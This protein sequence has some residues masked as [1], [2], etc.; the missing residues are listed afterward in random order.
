MLYR[1]QN[2]TPSPSYRA[3]AQIHLSNLSGV[4][5]HRAILMWGG[6]VTGRQTTAFIQL[7][8]SKTRKSEIFEA[9]TMVNLH[10]STIL[11]IITSM[12][13]TLK[14]LIL[15]KSCRFGPY[16]PKRTG[17]SASWIKSQSRRARQV[18]HIVFFLLKSNR[19]PA[20]LSLYK[21][22]SRRQSK[23]MRFSNC[24]CEEKLD[25]KSNPRRFFAHVR[26][27]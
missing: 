27:N 7:V 24:Q 11:A 17:K 23:L 9:A 20:T 21:A 22:D 10:Q 18:K 15:D 19:S 3:H 2:T 25:V 1:P 16:S 26:S 6:G 13:H 5:C 12:W 14:D 8:L 4:F